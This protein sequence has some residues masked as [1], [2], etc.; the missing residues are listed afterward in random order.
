[1]IA[2]YKADNSG[3]PRQIAAGLHD[4]LQLAE[5]SRDKARLEEQIFRWVA[6]QC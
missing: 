4:L 6:G 5:I 2:V 1:M 3:Q